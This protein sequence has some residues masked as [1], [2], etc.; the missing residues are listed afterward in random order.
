M[1]D[2][3]FHLR[4]IAATLYSINACD[5]NTYQI[6]QAERALKYWRQGKPVSLI[7]LLLR[8]KKKPALTNELM[9]IPELPVN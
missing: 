7:M 8:I 5:A 6:K 4:K 1:Q 9:T 3:Q 2:S